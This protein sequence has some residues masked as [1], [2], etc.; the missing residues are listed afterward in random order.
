MSQV[1]YWDDVHMRG[2]MELLAGS[3][4]A[5]VFVT[6]GVTP[7][8]LRV[9]DLGVGTGE[10]STALCDLGND[11][12][13]C[14]IAPLALKR[15]DARAKAIVTDGLLAERPFDMCLC[16]LVA[17]HLDDDE[18]GALL[19][20][21]RLSPGGVISLQTAEFSPPPVVDYPLFSRAA[22]ELESV[23]AGVGLV[24]SEVSASAKLYQGED[25]GAWWRWHI[26]KLRR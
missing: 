16:H 13:S 26:W 10:M 19:R 12:V 8:G 9:L 1:A 20:A 22:E 11:V 7:R 6:H 14:D 15:V 24:V 18:L 25:A 17:Q 21:I 2:D 23:F 4:P 3:L 5:D